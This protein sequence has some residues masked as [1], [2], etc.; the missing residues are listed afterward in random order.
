M[1]GLFPTSSMTGIR[2]V[3][4]HFDLPSASYCDPCPCCD[5]GVFEEYANTHEA[6][7]TCLENKCQCE[8]HG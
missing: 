6:L 8:C 7:V 3:D 4:R 5:E 2:R 1:I